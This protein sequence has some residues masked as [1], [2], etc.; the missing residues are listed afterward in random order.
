MSDIDNQKRF[1]IGLVGYGGIGGFHTA[2][3]RVLNLYYPDL[4]VQ[5][6]LQGAAARSEVS[7]ARAKEQGGYQYGTTDYL[8]LIQDPLVDLIDIC[9]PNDTHYEI[10]MAAL[11]AGKHVYLEKPL[12]LT[13]EQAKDMADRAREYS[14]VVQ[15]AFNYRFVPAVM[16]ARQLIEDGFLGDVVNFR[17]QYFHTGYLDPERPMSW[18]LSKERSGGGALV[19]LGSHAIDLMLYLVGPFDQLLAQTRTFVAQ[20]PVETGSDEKMPVKVDDH[21]QLLISLPGGGVGIVEVS[22]VA[23]G[24]TDDLNFEIHGTQGALKFDIMDPNWLYA[25]DAR[26]P[27]KP[28]GGKHGFKQIQTMHEYP[29]NKIPGGRSLVNA[30]GMHANSQYQVV[31][32]ALGLQEPSPSVE[33]GLAV[34]QVLDASYRSARDGCWVQVGT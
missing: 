30:L 14:Q 7:A 1:G 31:R 19:D 29:G 5:I 22:R 13:L 28:L 11:D 21:A 15:I 20:R 3:W 23:Q 6:H 33:E 24:T 17:V 9:T 26:D 4:P 10:F 25:Y 32:A 12:A 16:K 34:Q 27:K 18:R 2:N 8:D